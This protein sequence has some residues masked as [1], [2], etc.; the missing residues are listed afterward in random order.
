MI[1][2]SPKGT[3]FGLPKDTSFGFPSGAPYG[4]RKG[5]PFGVHSLGVLVKQFF[6]IFLSEG[7]LVEQFFFLFLLELSRQQ[8]FV[9][10]LSRWGSPQPGKK[11]VKRITFHTKNF[12]ILDGLSS[13]QFF[14]L[15]QPLGSLVEFPR[16]HFLEHPKG[17]S[18][19]PSAYELAI[20]KGKQR[21]TLE[22][23]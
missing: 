3:P 5:T 20:F 13:W 7:G 17:Y 21:K 19:W 16:R 18:I 1:L 15:F 14:L 11:L 2:S 6:F 10:G 9:V 8:F 4:L 22:S 12:P 23:P